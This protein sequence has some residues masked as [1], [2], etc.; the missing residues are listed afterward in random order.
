MIRR[1]CEA[2]AK[3]S[4]LDEL[5][6]ATDDK[7]IQEEVSSFG[8]TS[9]MT[10]KTHRNGT[11]RCAEVASTKAAEFSHVINIQ[12]DEPFVDPAQID[13]LVGTL[14]GSNNAI[15]TL[16][17][18]VENMN[19]IESSNEVKLVL[20]SSNEAMYFSRSVIPF[21][22]ESPDLPYYKHVGL[23]GFELTTLLE[24]VQLPVA[25]LE[26]SESLEQLRWLYHGYTIKVGI[27]RQET[28]SIDSPDDLEMALAKFRLSRG[29]NRL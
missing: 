28:I 29:T 3:A 2:A 16:A 17:K 24:L 8:G 14:T 7:R 6:V 25:E 1:V 12:G 13:L 11:E 21:H 20:N 27:T 9:V 23:Y 18:P 10:S 22:R 15:A 19:E 4:L 26:C 5:I